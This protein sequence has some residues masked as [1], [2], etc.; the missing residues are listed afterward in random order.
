M[1]VNIVSRLFEGIQVLCPR[2]EHVQSSN[3][4]T[5][6]DIA[7]TLKHRGARQRDNYCFVQNKLLLREVGC[8]GGCAEIAPLT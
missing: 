5:P 4:T 3:G 1:V 6:N 2:N 7:R 8:G